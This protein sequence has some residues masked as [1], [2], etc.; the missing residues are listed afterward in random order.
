MNSNNDYRNR[1]AK[2][3]QAELAELRAAELAEVLAERDEARARHAKDVHT[4][5][6]ERDEARAEVE[7]LR[8]ELKREQAQRVAVGV[9]GPLPVRLCPG[10]AGRPLEVEDEPSPSPSPK[11]ADL[12]SAILAVVE[13]I[14]DDLYSQGTTR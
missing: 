2:R 14:R 6:H 5:L 11:I 4:A 3:L 13:Q 10:R 12:L 9:G 1:E 7:R 8:A